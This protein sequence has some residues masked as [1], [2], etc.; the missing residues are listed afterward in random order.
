MFSHADL[1]ELVERAQA[2]DVGAI[3]EIYGRFAG[4]I[5]RYLLLRVYEQELAQDL[6]QEV[7]IKVIQGI[8]K[9]EY[10]DEKSFLGWLYTIAG[11][12]LSSYQRRRRLLS[13]PLDSQEELIDSRSQ[14]DV[15]SIC[16]RIALQQALEQLTD[17]QQ[18]VL[19]LRFFADMSNSEIANMLNRTEGAIKSL[20]HRALQSL[21][22]IMSRENDERSLPGSPMQRYVQTQ[23]AL[24]QL[25]GDLKQREVSDDGALRSGDVKRF[26]SRIGD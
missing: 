15:R 24:E 22:R 2:S 5:L 26:E 8:V 16:D 25:N 18:Q 3:S 17:D 23:D 19:A 1:Q 11:N 4:V 20:Q 13:T 9:F 10:R 6:T 21:N 12:V 14:N 7:F